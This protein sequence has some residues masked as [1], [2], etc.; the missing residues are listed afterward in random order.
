MLDPP[1]VIRD[2]R[3]W[4]RLLKNGGTML[5]YVSRY[6]W[7]LVSPLAL[8]LGAFNLA[9]K[10]FGL[11]FWGGLILVVGGLTAA[12][13]GVLGWR[14]RGTQQEADRRAGELLIS[15]LDQA[16]KAEIDSLVARGEYVHAIRRVR[17]LTGLRLIDAKRMV[18]SLH[19]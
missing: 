10:G 9:G 4:I 13:G 7:L 18:D 3:N 1:G 8:I 6:A 11:A 12:F 14:D 5:A 15:L 2:S 16:G 17:E 19:S